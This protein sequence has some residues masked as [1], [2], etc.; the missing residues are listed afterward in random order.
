MSVSRMSLKILYVTKVRDVLLAC[1]INYL[2]IFCLSLTSQ[3][4]TLITVG[5]TL[6]KFPCI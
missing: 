1:L 4:F 3:S 5:L 6:T 2:R